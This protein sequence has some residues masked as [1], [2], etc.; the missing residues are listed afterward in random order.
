MNIEIKYSNEDKKVLLKIEEESY[1]DIDFAIL[2]SLTKRVIDD[3]IDLNVSLNGFEN[4]PDIGENYKKMFEEISKLKL[5]PEIV[6]LKKKKV[7]E[8]NVE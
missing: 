8:D 6:E 3:Q 1:V 4:L 5:D 7:E 2:D